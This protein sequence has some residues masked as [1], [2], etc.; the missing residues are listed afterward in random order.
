MYCSGSSE[1]L[2]IVRIKLVDGR[3]VNVYPSAGNKQAAIDAAT[4]WD[5]P[6]PEVLSA[7]VYTRENHS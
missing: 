6:T 4:K 1:K 2:W 3:E 7:E 5:T